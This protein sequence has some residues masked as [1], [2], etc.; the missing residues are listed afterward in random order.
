MPLP[1]PPP[2]RE[3]RPA[4]SKPLPPPPPSRE[5]RPALSV[6]DPRPLPAPPGIIPEIKLGMI[7]SINDLSGN[8]MNPIWKVNLRGGGKVIVKAERQIESGV[9]FARG[10]INAISG[11]VTAITPT[12]AF[13]KLSPSEIGALNRCVPRP[14]S[15]TSSLLQSAQKTVNL[16]KMRFD[17]TF[18]SSTAHDVEASCGKKAMTP[19]ERADATTLFSSLRGNIR[20]WET[21]GQVLIADAVIG[22]HDRFNISSGTVGNFG[23]LIFSRDANGRVMRAQ[24]YDSLDPFSGVSSMMYGV[25]IQEWIDSDGKYIKD[26]KAVFPGLAQKIVDNMNEWRMR[27]LKLA[28]YGSA[29]VTWF[30][31]GMGAAWDKLARDISTKVTKGQGIPS[32]VMARAKYLGWV[33]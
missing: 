23:N 2:S 8:G 19:T 13:A 4:L 21:L 14:A 33:R 12:G 6:R 16:V 15:L 28:D 9:A 1:P 17:P 5:G 10:N 29:E 3:G 30:W 24:G 20:A 31:Q 32:G 18:H 25:D 27:P 22:N 11:I 7:E 26:N